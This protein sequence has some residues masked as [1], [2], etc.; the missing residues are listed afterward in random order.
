MIIILT[1]EDD[2]QRHPGAKKDDGSLRV[3]EV[4]KLGNN[5]VPEVVGIKAV[6]DSGQPEVRPPTAFSESWF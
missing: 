4:V 2:V 5:E 6:K 1:Q 3:P